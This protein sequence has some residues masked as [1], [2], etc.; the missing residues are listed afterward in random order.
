MP[1]CIFGANVGIVTVAQDVMESCERRM[2]A[3]AGFTP[4]VS[5]FS[6]CGFGG[7][8][9][10]ATS[11]ALWRS[12]IRRMLLRQ[13]RQRSVELL[14]LEAVDCRRLQFLQVVLRL[15]LFP[16]PLSEACDLFSAACVS[17]FPS[18]RPQAVQF[19]NQRALARGSL[20]QAVAE[21]Q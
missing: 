8:C 7:V 16:S 5:S 20:F 17:S 9:A 2:L 18:L 15:P 6:D 21:Q 12:A 14:R 3:D 1:I 4:L 11:R 19:Q 10:F 13:L